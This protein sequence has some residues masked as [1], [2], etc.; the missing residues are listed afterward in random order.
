MI[1]TVAML[2]AAAALA[3]TA[4]AMTLG[5]ASAQNGGQGGAVRAGAI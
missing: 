1:R 3:T 4:L 2:A 5:A